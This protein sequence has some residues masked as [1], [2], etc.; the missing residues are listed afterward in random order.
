MNNLHI[1]DEEIARL[2]GERAV[3]R[4]ASESIAHLIKAREE[5]VMHGQA[6]QDAKEALRAA[7]AEPEQ[8]PV[9]WELRKG[10]TDR[11]LLEITNDRRR[12]ADWRASLEEVVPLYTAPTPRKPLTD[13]QIH[14]VICSEY[15]S[16]EEF[17]RA[18]ERAHGIG[19]QK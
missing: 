19:E 15:D 1:I 5:R 14:A 18:I 3:L 9:A 2:Q 12:A 13:E 11:V 6:V 16:M 4:Q 7:I 10:K 8:E 17:A